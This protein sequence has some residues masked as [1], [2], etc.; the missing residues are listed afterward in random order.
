MTIRLET[1][2]PALF[3]E[4]ADVIRIFY[5]TSVKAEFRRIAG[6]IASMRWVLNTPTLRRAAPWA[7]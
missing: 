6:R 5:P 7:S 1:N 3:G 2:E 4:L